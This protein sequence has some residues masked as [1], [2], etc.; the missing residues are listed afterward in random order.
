MFV[1]LRN[2]FDAY[3]GAVPDLATASEAFFTECRKGRNRLFNNG[4]RNWPEDAKQ[5]D[6]LSWLADF[7]DKLSAF[8]Q[9]R[10]PTATI[11]RPLAKPNKPI[12]GS[13]GTRRMDI[14]FVNDPEAK[15][16]SRCH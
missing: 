9:A 13:T 16:E 1:G 8:G 11:R 10:R 12:D 14:G 2:F 4:W 7:I 6:V 5:D 15:K 3:F